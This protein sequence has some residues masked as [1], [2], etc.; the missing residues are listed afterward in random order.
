MAMGTALQHLADSLFVNLANLILLRHDSYLEFVKPVVKPDTW[1]LLR[2]APMFGYGLFPDSVLNA[3]E[4]D[5]N[6]HDAAGAAP[7]PNPG[8]SQHSN[9]RGNFRYRPYERRDNQRRSGSTEEEQQP[10]RQFSRNRGRG[11]A[12]G[13][14]NPCFSKARGLKSYK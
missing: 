1:N 3:A 11:H 5:I 7:G 12:R 6:K 8:A 4:Q 10:W 13:R 9:W 2:N 14:A